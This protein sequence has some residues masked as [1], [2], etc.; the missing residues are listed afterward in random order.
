M[1]SVSGTVQVG[2]SLRAMQIF[3]QDRLDKVESSMSTG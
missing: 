3:G 1:P 2:E